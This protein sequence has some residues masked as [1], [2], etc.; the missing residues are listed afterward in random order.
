MESMPVVQLM[1][2][3]SVNDVF[4]RMDVASLMKGEG[5]VEPRN[6]VIAPFKFVNEFQR[7]NHRIYNTFLGL[8]EEGFVTLHDKK[9]SR[10]PIKY[11]FS[12]PN[13]SILAQLKCPPHC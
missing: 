6:I 4:F 5:V 8:R 13:P 1:N 7:G 10:P 12:T 2:E 3:L 11:P 9:N